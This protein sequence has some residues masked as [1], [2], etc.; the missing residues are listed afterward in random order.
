M[1]I[2][3]NYLRELLTKHGITVRGVFHVGAHNC[4]ESGFY[5][6]FGLKADDVIWVDAMESKVT[7]AKAKGI[8]HVYQAVITDQDDQEVQFNVA[9]NVQSSSV[10]EFGTHAKEYPGITFTSHIPLNTVTVDTFF[11]RHP[12]LDPIKCNFWNFD[13]QGAE[14]MALK[15]STN[16]LQ[17]V[18]AIYLEVNTRELYKGCALLPDIDA[19]ASQYGFKRVSSKIMPQGW[20]DAMYVRIRVPK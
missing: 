12:E 17:H 15:G 8:P 4:E 14:L 10:L 16:A 3:Q 2:D 1:L 9:N 19:F 7:E 18:D 6:S 13:I 5:E 20:G 11:A